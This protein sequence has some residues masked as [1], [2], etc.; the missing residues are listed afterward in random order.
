MIFGIKKLRLDVLFL[1]HQGKRKDCLQIKN[2]NSNNLY[3]T[4]PYIF[5]LE[6]HGKNFSAGRRE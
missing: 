1:L 4:R 3:S 5:R 6:N 2:N